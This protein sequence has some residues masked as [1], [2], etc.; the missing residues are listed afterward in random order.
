MGDMKVSLRTSSLAFTVCF[1]ILSSL[2]LA[3]L[4]GQMRE[5]LSLIA[6]NDNE[7]IFNTLIAALRDHD[8]FGSAIESGGI[9]KDRIIGVAVYLDDGSSLYSWGSVPATFDASNLDAWKTEDFERYV[10]PS[11]KTGSLRFV[12]RASH[13]SPP[14]PPGKPLTSRRAESADDSPS[15]QGDQSFRRDRP[16]FFFD[17]FMRGDWV[18]IDIRHGSYWRGRAATDLVFPLLF[19]ALIVLA[20]FVRSLALRNVEY[21]ERIETQKNLVV[22]GTAAS[23]LAHEI[24]N[25]LLAIRLQT[26]ILRK[27][28]AGAGLE[29]I[30]II[31]SEVDRLSALTYRVNDY[32]REPQGVPETIDAASAVRE[33]S[34]RLCG[35]DAVTVVPG[36]AILYV[37]VDPD[38]F[39]SALENIFRNALES[40]GEE[41]SVE[42]RLSKA[43]GAV[44]IEVLDRGRGLE[45]AD[46]RRL[47]EPFYT[48]KGK[49]T[50]VGLS[51]TR[52][53]IEAA[54]GTISLTDRPDGGASAKI[55]LP[56]GD[57]PR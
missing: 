2:G 4:Y 53:F 54:G 51:I 9:L 21:R 37:R 38:R 44:E 41:S 33:V 10:I 32:L 15:S 36:G 11:Q 43:A 55:I 48:T 17:T 28:L 57:D 39:R 14:P 46:A 27:T 40:G 52:R 12:V 26:G 47:F 29:E 19:A 13:L 16:S 34:M 56:E 1:I 25:P 5:R 6:A 31:E 35:R 45:G 18:Y 30:G 20:L 50:G 49:G 7:R 3:F 42:V 8:D 23:T 24:K 22:L